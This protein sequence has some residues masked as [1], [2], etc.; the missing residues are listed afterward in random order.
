MAEKYILLECNRLQ[1]NLNYQ[2]ID[3]NQDPFR[4]NW[5]NNVNSY[6]IV[7]NPGDQIQLEAAAINTQGAADSTMEFLG[8][9]NANGYLDNVVSLNLGY[10]IC[11]T[12]FNTI[13]LPLRNTRTYVSRETQNGAFKNRPTGT[14]PVDQ[15]IDDENLLKNRLLGETYLCDYTDTSAIHNNDRTP[16]TNLVDMPNTAMVNNYSLSKRSGQIGNGF[17]IGG[18]YSVANENPGDGQ[19]TGSG[20]IIKVLDVASEGSNSGIPSK[21]QMIDPGNGSYQDGA[22]V[23]IKTAIDLP[24]DGDAK[25]KQFI[26]LTTYLNRN[27]CSK[28]NSTGNTGKR[29]YFAE[30]G[31]TGPSAVLYTGIPNTPANRLTTQRINPRFKVRSTDVFLELPPGLNTPDNVA[32]ILTDQ[33]S[34]PRKLHV[35]DTLPY[36]DYASYQVKSKGANDVPRKTRPPIIETPLY[37]PMSVN[38]NGVSDVGDK[39][40]CYDGARLMYYNSIAYLEPKRLALNAF[41]TLNYGLNNDLDTNAFN[42]GYRNANPA[43]DTNKGDYGNQT[44]GNLGLTPCIIHDLPSNANAPRL[45]EAPINTFVLTNIYFT[46]QNIRNLSTAFRTAERYMGTLTEKIDPNSE[47][48]KANLVTYLDINRYVDQLSA[49]VTLTETESPQNLQFNPNQRFRFKTFQ[50]TIR[51]HLVDP[52][53]SIFTPCDKFPANEGGAYNPATDKNKGTQPFAFE[54]RTDEFQLNDGQQLSYLPLSSRWNEDLAFDINNVSHLYQNLLDQIIAQENSAEA[55]VNETLRKFTFPADTSPGSAFAAGYIDT[56]GVRRSLQD[57]LNLSRKYDIMA[58]PVFPQLDDEMKK[59]GGRP[60]IAFSI[61]FELGVNPDFENKVM[62]KAQVFQIDHRNCQYGHFIG[63]D[64]SF[65]R[66]P[67]VLVRNTNYGD[68]R[69]TLGTTEP[70]D[71]N[72]VLMMGAVNPSVDFDS[73]LSRFTFSGF[74]TPITIGNGIPTNN[75]FNLEATGNPEQQCIDINGFKSCANNLVSDHGDQTAILGPGGGGNGPFQNNTF[76]TLNEFVA[77][78]STSINTSYSGLSIESIGLYTKNDSG[79][80]QKKAELKSENIFGPEFMSEEELANEF[81]QVYPEDIL[82]NTLLGKMGYEIDQLL[83]FVGSCAATFKDPI[84][85][86]SNDLNTYLLAY[87][88]RPKPMITDAFVGGAEYQPTST[89]SQDMPLYANGTNVGLE[90]HPAVVQGKITAQNLP[91]KLDYPYLLIYSSIIQGGTNTEYYG[92]VDG[93]SRLPCMSFVTRNYNAGD[94]F[95]GLESSFSYTAN[96]TFL[97][98]DVT[99]EIRLPDGTRPRLQPHNSVIYKITKPDTSMPVAPQLAPAQPIKKSKQEI[100]NDKR[101]REKAETS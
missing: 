44:I 62:G 47:D 7:V 17:R 95:Y 66:N 96:K 35:A 101:R 31:Y 4:N 49:G 41:N 27:F 21:I 32:Q 57:L 82:N 100:E 8:E 70:S 68:E 71:Y 25:T 14:E 38:Q 58:I 12:G 69:H 94:F 79:A 89:N 26:N 65:I 9:E 53:Q 83:P 28:N 3:D 92:G 72:S 63:Y 80:L 85:F 91:Q 39:F 2:N 84:T 36:I 10:Y 61:A 20:M 40:N 86:E 30:K 37:T 43:Q 29:Y 11:D 56:D 22:S 74:N 23:S 81:Y 55:N 46:E 73:N 54:R 90:S 75:Q 51:G 60:Y 64:P 52:T 15:L 88:T 34:R 45:K 16:Y 78:D 50:E 1:A 87:E 93:K 18:L 59:F 19:A 42:S 77:Q 6:G 99:T 98:T 67:A 24:G 5:T 33:L 76:L 97:L 48:Y 13:P